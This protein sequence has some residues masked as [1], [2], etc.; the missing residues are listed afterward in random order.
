MFRSLALLSL[1]A[2]VPAFP[3]FA[4]TGKKV[5]DPPKPLTDSEL[6]EGWISLFDGETLFAKAVDDAKHLESAID[7]MLGLKVFRASTD[8][9]LADHRQ[10]PLRLV[11]NVAGSGLALVAT[12]R[13]R[14]LIFLRFEAV[15]DGDPLHTARRRRGGWRSWDGGRYDNR[16]WRRPSIA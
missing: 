12:S 11:V 3:S 15:P 9:R 10:D 4:Q 2:L 14:P 8:A 1:L 13:D 16:F 5:T 7:A 6:A